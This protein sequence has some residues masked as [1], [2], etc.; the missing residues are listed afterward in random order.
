MRDAIR[1]LLQPTDHLVI[2]DTG[3]II[4]LTE[5]DGRTTRLAPDGHKI[6]DENTKIER[7]TK[8]DGEKLV[9]EISGLGSGKATQTFAVDPETHRLRIELH[10]E[11]GRSGQARTITQVYDAEVR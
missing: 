8:W 1:D 10:M 6:K 7:K 5:A 11:G 9:S 2:T 4:I 3:S